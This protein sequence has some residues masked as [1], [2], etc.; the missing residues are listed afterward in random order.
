MLENKEKKMFQY[1]LVFKFVRFLNDRADYW[2]YII[3]IYVALYY[4]ERN[5]P[6]LLR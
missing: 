1:S 5:I 6:Q 4:L 3:N 2:W